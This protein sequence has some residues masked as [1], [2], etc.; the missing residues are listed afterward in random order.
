[1]REILFRG[2]R[3][4]NGEWVEGYY[5][6]ATHHWHKKGIHEDWIITGASQN[7]GWFTLQGSHAVIPESIGQYTTLKDKNGKRIFEG[8]IL[9]GERYPFRD[10]YGDYNYF[11]EVFWSINSPAFGIYTFKNPK[12]NVGGSSTGNCDYLEDFA[13]EDWEIIGNVHDN[14]ELVER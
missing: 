1:M 14:P 5:A 9:K 8:D 2:K 6:K 11:A 3:V 10:G 12:S 7:G 4:D 13:S